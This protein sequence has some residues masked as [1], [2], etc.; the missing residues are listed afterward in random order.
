[1]E[2]LLI[3]M[4]KDFRI[5]ANLRAINGDAPEQHRKSIRKIIFQKEFIGRGY[6]HNSHK[7]I[8]YLLSYKF[9]TSTS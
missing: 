5:D 8:T 3:I 7:I 9:I 2:G 6:V 1:M 4:H